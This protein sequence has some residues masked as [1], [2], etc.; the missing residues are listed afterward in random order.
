M[1][2]FISRIGNM[3]TRGLL[4]VTMLA[5]GSSAVVAQ[6]DVKVRFSW[7]LKGEYA[8]FYHA[9]NTGGFEASELNVRLGEGAGSQAALGALVQGQED[10]V[11]MPAIFAMTAIQ[12]GMPVKLIALYHRR[13]PI[14][15][16]SSPENPIESHRRISRGR[17]WQQLLERREQPTLGRSAR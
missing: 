15:M 3:M 5:F 2:R 11:V 4:V 9:L 10:V 8:P 7:K 6:D 17:S 1:K 12:R 13:A 14:I 16:I